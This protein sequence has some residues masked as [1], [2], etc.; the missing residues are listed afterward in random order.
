MRCPPAP[1]RAV[2]VLAFAASGV[3]GRATIIDDRS[4]SLVWPAAGVA[5]VW[6]LVAR[7]RVLGPDTVLLALATGAVNGLT[8]ASPAMT[9]VFV[10][11]NVVQVWVVVA[12]LRRRA[13][14]L[15]WLGGRGTFADPGAVSALILAGAAGALVGSLV[16]TAGL[17]VAD[18]TAAWGS[19][20]VWWGRNFV[21][22]V[23]VVAIAHLVAHRF[24]AGRPGRSR[25]GRWEVAALV[26]SFAVA[27]TAAVAVGTERPLAFVVVVLTVWAAA[28]TTTLLT[29]VLAST[30][31]S[32]LVLATLAGRGP[33]AD[34]TSPT[35]S[36]V[37][38]QLLLA[39]LIVMGLA[40]STSREERDR[41]LVELAG[42]AELNRAV[43]ESIDE[44]VAVLDADGRVVMANPTTAELL[45]QEGADRA[46]DFVLLDVAGRRLPVDD[47]PW[48]RA[49]RGGDVPAEDLVVVRRAGD[50][51]TLSVTAHRLDL[52]GRPHA[53][54]V[55]RDV[56]A[57]RLQRDQLA[58]FAATV[59]HD[60]R[61]P[62][63]SIT[64][65]VDVLTERAEELA[66]HACGE[67]AVVAFPRHVLEDGLGRI[68]AAGGRM[69][70]L[71]DGLLRHAQARD[72]PLALVELDL[73]E[74]C[75]LVV[76]DRGA[77]DR[78]VVGDL[79]TVV[80]D[81]TL[82]TQVLD[83]VVGN[84]LKYV[85]PGAAAEVVVAGRT[86]AGVVEVRIS[87]RGI[88]ID[89]AAGDVFAPFV[90]ARAADYPGT[91]LGLAICRT[92]VERHG[93][94][95]RA[96]PRD[97]GGTVVVLELPDPVAPDRRRS[98]VG[99]R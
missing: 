21:G 37:L 38:A 58:A 60:L 23:V 32:A 18:G 4:L 19:W 52:H 30:S 28:R 2:G 87:D 96:V 7:A 9:A 68:A 34:G 44:G 35:V 66:P 53:V 14:R 78:V 95:I 90:R 70:A 80:G 48:A 42:A 57:D 25:A 16:G 86:V 49:L 56:T 20:F 29:T 71:I 36:A 69:A 92:V 3:A 72:V 24:V 76:A 91:G 67:H 5:V 13:P 74:L 54:V 12:L 10:V 6:F 82:L 11:C 39:T 64:G 99:A 27:T 75:R 84:A 22:V 41:L 55:H 15:L 61:G 62:L 98:L 73:G 85:A 63:T 33:L 79:P 77:A 93:G 8:G 83:N 65:W 1:T 17:A 81:R 88:G 46:Q 45:R 94:R 26:L 50:R 59:A 43:L 40:L 97:G 89:P 31:G 47:L 51:R